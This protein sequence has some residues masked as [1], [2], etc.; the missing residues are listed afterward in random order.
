MNRRGMSGKWNAMWHSSPSPKYARTSDGHWLASAS[1]MRPGCRLSS[2]RR[3]VFRIGVR[4]RQVR[5]LRAFALDE[6]RHGVEPHAVDPMSSQKRM[7]RST[8]FVTMRVV[9]VQIRLMV[10]E[11][12]PEVL[13]G[14]RIPR[15]VRSLG[16]LEDDRHARVLL[17][18]VAPDVEVA[19]RRAPRR[20]PRRLEPGML[21]GRVVDHELRDDPKAAIVR[22]IQERQEVP[23]RAV[24]RMNAVVVRDVVAVVAER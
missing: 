3:M 13:A 20:P 22:G 2:S 5:A 11:P 12:V 15:P 4:L 10:E 16:V 19:L 18:G 14:D 9:E 6:I 24:A 7:T 1:S 8:A 17:I 23:S 21:I